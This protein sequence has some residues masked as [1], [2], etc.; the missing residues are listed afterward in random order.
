MEYTRSTQRIDH[1]IGTAD[2]AEE[3]KIPEKR[4]WASVILTMLEDYERAV[5]AATLNI[6]QGSHK[7]TSIVIRHRIESLRMEARGAWIGSLC[8]H[9]NVAP[10]R[11]FTRFN[12][13]DCAYGLDRV[14]YTTL[15]LGDSDECENMHID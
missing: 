11:L 4:L 1:G 12:E 3:V 2:V 9:L 8:D 10:S 5:N 14:T 6:R 13:I 7:E 15:N